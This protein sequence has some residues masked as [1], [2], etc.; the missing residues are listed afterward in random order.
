MTERFRRLNFGNLQIDVTIEDPS[1][2]VRP[3]TVRVNQRI[4]LDEEFIEFICNE[5]EKSVQHFDR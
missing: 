2:Y 1:A 5:N 3:F 4:L